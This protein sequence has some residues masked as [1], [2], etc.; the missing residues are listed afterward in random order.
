MTLA[1]KILGW[2]QHV[3]TMLQVRRSPHRVTSVSPTSQN[4]LDE[5]ATARAAADKAAA[6]LIA[7]EQ[8]AAIR[9]QQA[10]VRA[11]HIKAKR[12]KQKLTEESQ[13][14]HTSQSRNTKAV[15]L[16][17]TDSLAFNNAIN[18]DAVVSDFAHPVSC[19]SL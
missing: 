2:H 3:V 13:H 5:S 1:Q 15:E 17:H 7:E 8:L 6:E 12:H 9:H 10:C 19:S 4:A 14:H 18:I 11:A 16:A